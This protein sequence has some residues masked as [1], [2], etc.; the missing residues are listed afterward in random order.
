[1]EHF[2]QRAHC[3]Y[4]LSVTWSDFSLLLLDLGKLDLGKKGFQD[5]EDSLSPPTP[6]LNQTKKAGIAES[7]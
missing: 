6:I 3:S 5:F 7:L 2:R 1:M 4:L